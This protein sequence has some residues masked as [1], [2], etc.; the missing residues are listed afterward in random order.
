MCSAQVLYYPGGQ[1]S[2]DRSDLLHDTRLAHMQCAKGHSAVAVVDR[3][4]ANAVTPKVC[5]CHPLATTPRNANSEKAG[6]SQLARLTR[7][8]LPRCWHFLFP[9][10]SCT[11]LFTSSTTRNPEADHS[12][13]T[14]TCWQHTSGVVS[15]VTNLS[16]ATMVFMLV[17]ALGCTV[18]SHSRRRVSAQ[19]LESGAC[20]HVAAI[21]R[22]TL[23]IA[24]V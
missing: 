6:L 24:S 4:P 22:I 13:I 15:I 11:I 1:L 20:C 10:E 2:R 3:I 18:A 19:F 9:S 23:G 7:V 8:L 5:S 21:S 12:S 17:S 16:W 14:K